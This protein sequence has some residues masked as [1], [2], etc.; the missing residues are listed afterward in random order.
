MPLWPGSPAIATS[1]PP[2]V[3]SGDSG[4]RPDAPPA[5]QLEGVIE[6]ITYQSEESGYTV[7][8]V[9]NNRDRLLTVVGNL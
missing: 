1:P 9:V 7:A 8:R 5:S 6:R 4:Q 2:V 3:R